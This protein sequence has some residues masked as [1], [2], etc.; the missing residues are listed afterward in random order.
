MNVR[1]S[2]CLIVRDEADS[3][4]GCLNSVSG[5]ADEIIV[6]DTGSLDGTPELAARLGARVLKTHWQDDFAAARNV[7]IEAAQGDWIF[8]IDADE[9]LTAE[10]ATSL[11]TFLAGDPQA[12]RV[13]VKVLNLADTGAVSTAFYAV[14]LFSNLPQL[15]YQRAFHEHLHDFGEPGLSVSYQPDIYL[16]HSGYRSDVALTKGKRERNRRMLNKLRSREPDQPVWLFYS[17]N[18][19]DNVGEPARALNEYLELLAWG[20]RLGQSHADPNYARALIEVLG[21]CRSLGLIDQ[22]LTLAL[23]LQKLSE[24]IPDYWYL[25]GSLHRLARDEEQAIQCFETCLSF[26]ERLLRV[27][28]APAHLRAGPLQQLIQLQR[29]RLYHPARALPERETAEQALRQLCLQG[30]A[31]C[32]ELADVWQRYL[33]EALCWQA[34]YQTGPLRV[35]EHVLTA[36]LEQ[37]NSQWPQLL[38][39]SPEVLSEHPLA[40][41][42]LYGAFLFSRDSRWLLTL[43]D[44][45]TREQGAAAARQLLLEAR[46]FSPWDESLR[47]ALGS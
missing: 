23:S 6:C 36:P 17:A 32:P 19:W 46:L 47:Q 14:R 37:L 24:H 13:N 29:A 30:L 2:V 40:R 22:G 20:E 8:V 18:Y 34:H 44:K 39:T 26:D 10:S 11:R 41:L 42:A 25:R 3:L 38:Q 9:R 45:L 16:T 28:Y 5:I 7:S 15:R 43:T 1:L 27:H 4:T 31:D 21:C 35:P 33:L 12:G